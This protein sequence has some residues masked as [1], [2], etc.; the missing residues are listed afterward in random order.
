MRAG[1][2]LVV[3]AALLLTACGGGVPRVSTPP[4]IPASITTPSATFSPTELK[5]IFTLSPL[6]PPPS[7]P[8]NRFA[9][10]PAAARLG[11]FLFF[12]ARLSNNGKVSCASCHDPAKSFT[13]AQPLPIQFNKDLRH[14]PSLWNVAYNRW[15]FWD[16]R[17]DSLWSQ[18][19]DPLE[20][21]GEHGG[22]RWQ[23]ARLMF[24]DPDLRR[25]YERIFGPLPDMTDRTRFP[26]SAPASPGAAADREA[27]DRVFVNIGKA[28]E[29]YERR[30]VSAHSPFDVFVEGLRAGDP[31]RLSALSPTAQR[32]LKLFIG[33]ANCRSC[34]HGPNFT[35]G[36]F[37]D[38]GIGALDPPEL[39][40][41]GRFQGINRL[42]NSPFN[43]LGKFSDDPDARRT[44]PTA[45]LVNQVERRGQFKTPSLRNVALTAPYMHRGQLA[46]LDD[47]VA[48]YSTLQIGGQD[49]SPAAVAARQLAQ[50]QA[51]GNTH[52]H[53][54]GSEHVLTAL[55]LS[56]S[57]A[58]DLIAFLRSLTDD[59]ID[60]ALLKAPASPDQ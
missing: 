44:H 37:H 1:G 22:T 3:I 16:G 56:K 48:F 28:L 38:T 10:D 30:L 34:H 58:D 57:E 12:D 52:T 17:A 43:A 26:V 27:V 20:H 15:Y 18:A 9:D 45:F 13:D 29:A 35:D 39:Q 33:P 23:Y 41:L 59:R 47:V 8:T 19:L 53:P 36:E 60:P 40:D 11:Q 42:V 21:A 55:N 32:G 31:A 6:P 50:R 46:S 25:A 7:D 5:E 54:G 51:Q 2:A 24:D 4:A 49:M 14:V